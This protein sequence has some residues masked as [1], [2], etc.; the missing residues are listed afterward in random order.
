MDYISLAK[1]NF[2]HTYSTQELCIDHADGVRVYGTDGKCYLDMVAGIAV[3]A[4]GYNNKAIKDR[5]YSLQTVVRRLMKRPS[6]QPGNMDQ[7]PAEAR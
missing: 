7:E 5:G 3:N 1:E 2:M 4:L 6:K